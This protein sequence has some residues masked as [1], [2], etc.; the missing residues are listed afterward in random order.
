M[1]SRMEMISTS[2]VDG[3]LQRRVGGN[4]PSV[5]VGVHGKGIA[6]GKA[7]QA[8]RDICLSV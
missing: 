4:V 2:L 8:F 6:D 1:S 5:D 3:L 7:G